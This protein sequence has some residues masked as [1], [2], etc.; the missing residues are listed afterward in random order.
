MYFEALL[1][2][3]NP[4]VLVLYHYKIFLFISGDSLCLEAYLIWSESS[5]FSFPVLTV[6]VL[7]L[8]F[9]FN[10]LVSLYV[11]YISYQYYIFGSFVTLFWQSLF[12]CLFGMSSPFIFNLITDMIAENW[13]SFLLYPFYFV[14]FLWLFSRL[15]SFHLVFKNLTMM[16]PGIGFSSI[17]IL[18]VVFLV[19]WIWDLMSHQFWKVVSHYIVDIFSALFFLSAPSWTP[20]TCMVNYVIISYIF[21]WLFFFNL[22]SI[23]CFR[24]DTFF[25]TV[26]CLFCFFISTQLFSLSSDF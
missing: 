4:D 16:C 23:F 21:G 18:L 6:C 12:S 17:F 22:L 7:F 3:C 10:L 1:L 9:Y 14:V 24:L 19:L 20:V 11:K 26:L 13:L 5:N 8:S 2:L 15:F 25:W